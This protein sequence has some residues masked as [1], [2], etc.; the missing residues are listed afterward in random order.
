MH[1]LPLT[2]LVLSG[3]GA[4]AAYQVGVLRAIARI[5]RELLGDS[6][7]TC[8]PF[9]VISGTS[10]GAINGAALACHADDFDTGVERLTAT[11]SAFHAAQ[12]YRCDTLGLLTNG[13]RWMGVMSLG[14]AMRRLR[15]R[16]LLDN[17]PLGALLRQLVPMHRLP[18]LL[19][20]RHLHALA[21]SAS[22]Y[23][24]GQHVTFYQSAAPIPPW[25]RTQRMAARTTLVHEHLMASSAIPF[26]FP[27]TRLHH[28][29]RGGWYGDGSM[30]QASP[31]SPAIHLGA[32]RLV[33]I[34]AGRMHQPADAPLDDAR[35]PSLAQVAGHAMSSIFL[36]ALAA[37]I[38]RM[39]RINST[40][41]ML[42]PEQRAGHP[43]APIE[44]VIIAPSER[45]DDMAARH[46]HRLPRSVQ[47]LLRS[48]GV[49]D[50]RREGAALASYLLFESAFTQELLALGEQDGMAQRDALASFLQPSE[51]ALALAQRRQGSLPA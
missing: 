45:L 42:T 15:P 21:I 39:Q 12:V 32:R 9:G 50:G 49:R 1:A 33:I 28:E 8:N 51:F 30:R 41:G 31:L 20:R 40:L 16:S 6:P 23:S 43:L 44:A 34:G 27:A 17:S 3:G 36:D 26:I 18:T 14:W 11:W 47:R 2:G 10:A 24:T 13:L 35:Y 22:S 37:D 25:I 29:G 38:E 19:A 4:R 5:R 7:G 48:T 46:I